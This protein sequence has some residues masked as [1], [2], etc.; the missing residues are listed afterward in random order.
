MLKFLQW[1]SQRRV[2]ASSLRGPSASQHTLA[3]PSRWDYSSPI[4]SHSPDYHSP[5]PPLFN[6]A[7]LTPMHSHPALTNKAPFII[8]S[9][10]LRAA[11]DLLL[12]QN[13]H[14]YMP[15]M[16]LRRCN[17]SKPDPIAHT[18]VSESRPPWWAM[19]SLHSFLTKKYRNVCGE[20]LT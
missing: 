2:M 3:F 14:K 5:H 10:D 20:R 7:S 1:A 12:L 18:L 6:P 16:F 8:A 17:P 9:W 13:D 4:T 19:Y 11:L 15:H